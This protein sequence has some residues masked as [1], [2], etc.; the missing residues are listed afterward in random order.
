MK[1]LTFV[2][3]VNS[4]RQDFSK[5]KTWSCSRNSCLLF[6]INVTLNI[7]SLLNANWLVF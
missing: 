6:V 7:I 5:G 3:V 2:D 1:V 4:K